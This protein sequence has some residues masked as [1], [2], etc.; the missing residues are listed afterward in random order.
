MCSEQSAHGARKDGVLLVLVL[1]VPDNVHNAPCLVLEDTPHPG[2]F[3]AGAPLGSLRDQLGCIPP[4]E[5][6][7]L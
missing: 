3:S 6:R 7:L 2:K 5:S 1:L 4:G